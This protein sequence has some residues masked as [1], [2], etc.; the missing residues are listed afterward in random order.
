MLK[1]LEL[2]H[3][4]AVSQYGQLRGALAIDGGPIRKHFE[5]IL[6]NQVSTCYSTQKERVG[7]EDGVIGSERQIL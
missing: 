6:Y 4:S 7:I 3:H 2:R 5:E 1:S